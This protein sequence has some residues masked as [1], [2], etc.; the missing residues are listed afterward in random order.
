MTEIGDLIFENNSTLFEVLDT[1]NVPTIAA[2]LNATNE[3]LDEVNNQ[4]R[5][6]G[7]IVDQNQFATTTA[8][9]AVNTR[10]DSTES[11]ISDLVGEN[12][13]LQSQVHV[14]DGR[15]DST[16]SDVARLNTSVTTLQ[17][18]VDNQELEFLA[19]SSQVGSI[20]V[21]IIGLETANSILTSQVTSLM[22][23]VSDLTNSYIALNAQVFNMQTQVNSLQTSVNSLTLNRFSNDLLVRGNE[24][25]FTWREGTNTYSRRTTFSGANTQSI[26][27]NTGYACTVLDTQTG[28]ATNQTVYLCATFDYLRI[29]GVLNYAITA[30]TVQY[31]Y[32]S[33]GINALTGYITYVS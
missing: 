23:Q 11:Q 21:S 10:L 27:A 7:L 22:G 20:N 2:Q 13:S 8:F 28:T 6:L 1:L 14:L 16:L 5:Q 18:I 24:Y 12:I 33:T 32:S 29:N 15:V 17:A 26:L 4:L 3:R 9:I 19:L 31:S 30:G 25:I